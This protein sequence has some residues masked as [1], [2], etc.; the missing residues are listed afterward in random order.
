MEPGSSY[1]PS[2]GTE[3]MFFEDKFCSNCIHEK[4]CHTGDENDLQCK[5]LI[6]AFMYDQ[7]DKEYPKEWVYDANG[8]PT[9]TAFKFWDWG[10]DD[11]EGGGINEPPPPE[12]YNPMQL[13]MPFFTD[14]ILQDH[15]IKELQE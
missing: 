10:R 6:N 12:P 15:P 13:T 5:I 3:G 7:R 11:G 1:R 2:N 14:D 9:C 4:Y 8:Q